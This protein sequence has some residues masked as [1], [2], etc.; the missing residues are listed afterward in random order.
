MG[1]YTG[2]RNFLDLQTFITN[3]SVIDKDKLLILHY[4]RLT[5]LVSIFATEN[6]IF[7]PLRYTN[8]FLF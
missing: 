2:G 1:Y 3:E 4:F 5:K 7:L 6:N 8:I